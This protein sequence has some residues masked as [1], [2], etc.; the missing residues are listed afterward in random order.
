MLPE[1][2]KVRKKESYQAHEDPWNCSLFV[3]GAFVS[4]L[5]TILQQ[6]ADQKVSATQPLIDLGIDSLIAV[7][8]RTW[9][10]QELGVEI[11][12]LKLL[13]GATLS[14]LAEHA[15]SSLPENIVPDLQVAESPSGETS[16]AEAESENT[17]QDVESTSSESS[18]S[19]E[20]NQIST[21]TATSSLSVSEKGELNDQTDVSEPEI[22]SSE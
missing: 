2:F 12:V 22:P 14:D 21:P 15:A 8:I 4:R 11:P 17:S 18:D 5:N 20:Q 1:L 10:L 13:G 6:P 19:I 16:S 7:E 3:L 9:F